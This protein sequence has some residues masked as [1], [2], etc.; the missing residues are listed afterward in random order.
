M[1]D[2][3]LKKLPEKH[4]PKGK[5][6]KSPRNKICKINKDGPIVYIVYVKVTNI[7]PIS[8][9]DNDGLGKIDYA[10]VF[11]NNQDANYVIDCLNKIFSWYHVYD[12]QYKFASPYTVER[13]DGYKVVSGYYTMIGNVGRR[14]YETERI[15]AIVTDKTQLARVKQEVQ[16]KLTDEFKNKLKMKSSLNNSSKL[17]VIPTIH[18]QRY[19]INDVMPTMNLDDYSISQHKEHLKAIADELYTYPHTKNMKQLIGAIEYM[20]PTKAMKSGGIHYQNL[21][22]DPEFQQRWAK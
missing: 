19:R 5:K 18:V 3:I 2:Y 11:T 13:I 17:H 1:K 10:G 20:P 8:A 9:K 15:L 7:L 4:L 12:D 6:L 16:A 22:N 14:K 21:V